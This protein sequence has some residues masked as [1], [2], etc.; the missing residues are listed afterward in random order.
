MLSTVILTDLR[1]ARQAFFTLGR[2]TIESL[3]ADLVIHMP[4]HK[5][6]VSYI[7][8]IKKS[9]TPVCVIFISLLIC[10]LSAAKLSPTIMRA[11]TS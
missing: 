3:S 8:D 10:L 5:R 1:N 11:F 2:F 9:S 6:E 7:K 4:A